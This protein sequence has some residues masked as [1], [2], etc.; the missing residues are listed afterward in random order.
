MTNAVGGSAYYMSAGMPQ[1]NGTV[2]PEATYSVENTT[3]TVFAMA[4]LPLEANVLN[5]TIMASHMPYVGLG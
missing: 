4:A 5:M 1:A 3:D 2:M